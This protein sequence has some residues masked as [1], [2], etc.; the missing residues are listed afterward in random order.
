MNKN[1]KKFIAIAS[2]LLL[3]ASAVALQINLS[4]ASSK[5]LL[6]KIDTSK[7]CC[8]CNKDKNHSTTKSMENK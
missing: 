2:C 3:S 4:H 8:C 7:D 1:K 6:E 5:S